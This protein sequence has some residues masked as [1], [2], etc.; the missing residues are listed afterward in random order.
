[1]IYAFLQDL[2]L[3]WPSGGL[4]GAIIIPFLRQCEK[5]PGFLEASDWAE[6]FRVGVDLQLICLEAVG[7]KTAKITGFSVR[8]L[9]S[10]VQSLSVGIMQLLK[11]PISALFG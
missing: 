3:D 1:M 9:Q 11:T 8:A 7:Q 6:R 4:L 10:N 5:L 2:T